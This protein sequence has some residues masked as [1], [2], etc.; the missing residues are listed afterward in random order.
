MKQHTMIFI[1]VISDST[2]ISQYQNITNNKLQKVNGFSQIQLTCISMI[3][4]IMNGILLASYILLLL[5]KCQ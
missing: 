3:G 5:V 4:I 2:Q 1:L